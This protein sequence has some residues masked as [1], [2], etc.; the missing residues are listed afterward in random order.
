MSTG[1]NR[2]IIPG[3][4]RGLR[5]L[6]LFDRQHPKWTA[7]ELGRTLQLPRTAVFR[8]L[9]TLEHLQFLEQE[10]DGGWRLGPAVLRMGFEYVAPLEITDLA[11]P[12]VDRLRDASGYAAQLVIRDGRHIV[13]ILKAAGNSAFASNVQVGTRLVCAHE[14][15]A[16]PRFKQAFIRASA[17]DAVASVQLDP[18]LPVIPG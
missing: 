2:Y 15:A 14:C 9:Q 4:E 6:Q 12:V 10:A 13:V 1:E 7:P 16:H 11:R 3:L 5:L 8:L 18:R 17:R